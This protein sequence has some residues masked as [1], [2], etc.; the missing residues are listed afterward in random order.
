MVGKLE[1]ILASILFIV[2]AIALDSSIKSKKNINR[3]EGN[4]IELKDAE[5]VEVNSTDRV[6]DLKAKFAYQ[7]GGVWYFNDINFTASGVKELIAVKATRDK[8]Y[9]E[10]SGDVFML[11]D[12]DSKYWAD[13][14]VYL[15]DKKIFYTMGRFRVDRNSTV[16]TG[17]NFY[18]DKIQGFSRA[19]NV[20][21]IYQMASKDG[22]GR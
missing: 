11:S 9:F 20:H 2:I 18:H 10:L 12:D 1:L 17:K 3:T 6:D 14:A 19:E 5:L 4:T 7:N 16:A 13:R 21:G 15:T 8:N 22:K